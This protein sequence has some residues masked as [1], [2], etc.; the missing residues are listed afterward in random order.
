M[1]DVDGGVAADV[2]ALPVDDGL[3][4]ALRD[5]HV[6]AG[7]ANG[8]LASGDLAAGGQLVGGGR[9]RRG[10]PHAVNEEGAEREGKSGIQALLAEAGHDGLVAAADAAWRNAAAT[11]ALDEFGDGLPAQVRFVPDDAEYM[12][13][14]LCALEGAGDGEPETPR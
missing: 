1:G 9:H 14:I 2:K 3:L 4:A 10:G 12:V 5:L 13:H 11:M 6:G 7:L 8:D